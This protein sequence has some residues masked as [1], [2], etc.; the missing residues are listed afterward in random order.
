MV[1]VFKNEILALNALG[2]QCPPAGA[3]HRATKAWRWVFDPLRTHCFSPVAIK[4]P[5]RLLRANEPDEKCSCW[6]LSMY[7]SER[8]SIRAFS[9]IEKNFK[10]IRKTLGSHVALVEILPS[11]GLCTPIDGNGHFDFHPYVGSKVSSSICTVQP[12]P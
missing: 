6:A 2:I 8:E 7:D 9:R 11:D 10:K 12:I 5:P 4:H 1:L 3:S